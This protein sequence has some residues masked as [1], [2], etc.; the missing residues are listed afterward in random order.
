MVL[1]SAASETIE[2]Q[3][4]TN[5]DLKDQIELPK[6]PRDFRVQYATLIA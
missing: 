6:K 4:K 3:I 1:F 2:S 5:L